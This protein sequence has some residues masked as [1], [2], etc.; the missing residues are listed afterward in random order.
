MSKVKIE[1]N[2]DGIKE[3]LKSPE[4]QSILSQHG[5]DKAR[6]AGAGYESAV[7]VYKTRAVA[8]VFP[9][10]A[11]ANRDNMENNTLLKVIG[12]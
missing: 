9:N 1:L 3:L 2:S 11:E 7:H 6:Q 4:M 10:T 8:N 5:A 12:S